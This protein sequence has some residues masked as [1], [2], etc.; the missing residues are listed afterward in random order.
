MKAT[1]IIRKVDQ[2]GRIVVPKELRRLLHIDV[3]EPVEIFV[4]EDTIYLRKY[5]PA[6]IFC[7]QAKNLARYKDKLVCKECLE[8]I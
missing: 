3:N 8:K 5:N 7:G 1:G 6:C 2:L 4:D